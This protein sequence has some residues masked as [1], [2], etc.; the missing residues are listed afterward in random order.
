MEEVAIPLE[1]GDGVDPVG[2]GVDPVGDGV[3]PSG[4]WVD[5]VRGEQEDMEDTPEER[6]E[7]ENKNNIKKKNDKVSSFL[8]ASQGS[9]K[10][11]ESWIQY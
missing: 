6:P 9:I 4:D 2:D 11:S 10:S 7:P 8:E 5:V 1:V 3:D